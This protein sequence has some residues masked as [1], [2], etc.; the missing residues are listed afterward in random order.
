MDAHACPLKFGSCKS[1]LPPAGLFPQSSRGPWAPRGLRCAQEGW[2]VTWAHAP[3]PMP[4]GPPSASPGACERRPPAPSRSSCAGVPRYSTSIYSPFSPLTLHV[5]SCRGPALNTQFPGPSQALFSPRSHCHV[6]SLLP[7]RS[8]RTA[9][10][11]RS[12]TAC[13]RFCASAS[14]FPDWRHPSSASESVPLGHTFWSNTMVKTGQRV[15]PR[16]LLSG[17]VL[18]SWFVC[19]PR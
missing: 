10:L 7:E 5:A 19:F 8:A 3:S 9:M 6:S 13:P 2:R 17:V 14:G 4:A 1:L 12:L 15:P 16:Q 11:S 18:V